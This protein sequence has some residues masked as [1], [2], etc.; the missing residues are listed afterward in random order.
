MSSIRL[1]LGAMVLVASP[2]AAQVA[3]Q[4]HL[5]AASAPQAEEEAK[6]FPL[7]VGVAGGA[8]SYEGGRQEQALGAVVRWAATPWLAL[9][10]TPTAVHVKEPS[11]LAVGTF[12][13][14][15]GIVDLPLDATVEHG[16]QAPWNPGVAFALGVSLPLGDTATGF[17]A[18]KVGYSASAGLGFSPLSRVWVHLGAGRSL[19]DVAM[20]SAFSSGDGWGDASAG[21][22]VTERLDVSGGYSTDIGAV[23]STVGHSR[24]INGGV[25]YAMRGPTTFNL[26]ASRGVSG[27]A[28]KWSLAI[29][30]GTAFPYLSH[31]GA[32]SPLGALSDTFGGGTHGLGGSTGTG[33]GTGTGGSSNGKGRGRNAL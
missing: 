11:A 22:S 31:L 19:S 32:G 24:S 16:F 23:D 5:P 33:T 13:G 12:E 2:L 21:V 6:P 27:L 9:S 29:G 25:S 3:K 15:S 28:P 1:Y 26:N 8:L 17:G 30:F 14:R 7:Q 10:A 18:G 20:Q 4:E